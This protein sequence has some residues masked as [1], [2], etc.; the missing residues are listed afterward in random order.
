MTTPLKPNTSARATDQA[1][2]QAIW[3]GFGIGVAVLIFSLVA[4]VGIEIWI[5]K[6]GPNAIEYKSL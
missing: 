4:L 6:S 5:T 2:S 1:G 3:I